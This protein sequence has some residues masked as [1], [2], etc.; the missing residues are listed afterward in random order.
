MKKLLLIS[1]LATALTGCGDPAGDAKSVAVQFCD[2][3][4]E[5]NFKMKDIANPDVINAFQGLHKM[6]MDMYKHNISNKIN[7]SV[8]NVEEVNTEKSYKVSYENMNT[9]LVNF[10]EDSDSFK[11][12]RQYQMTSNLF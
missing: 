8:T 10:D 5:A 1:V 12:Q 3:I 9:V 4:A 11:V 6:N 7:C 2:N